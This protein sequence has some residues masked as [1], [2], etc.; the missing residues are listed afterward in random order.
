MDSKTILANYV[1]PN[2][3]LVILAVV[4]L[5]VG[6]VSI[7]MISISSE[8]A[9]KA[10]GDP[11]AFHNN[12]SAHGTYCYAD[13]IGISNWLYKYD[14]NTYYTA[15]DADGNL[16]TICVSDSTYNAMDAQF[17]WW[18]SEDEDEAPPAPYRVEGIAKTTTITIKSNLSTSWEISQSEYAELFGS[19]YLDTKSSP[20][21]DSASVWIFA[22]IM[23]FS[24][25]LIFFLCGIPG[26]ANFKKCMTNLEAKNLLDSAARELESPDTVQFGKDQARLSR[27]FLYCKR[28]GIVIPYTDILWAYRRQVKQYFIFTVS[29]TLVVHTPYGEFNAIAVGGNDK[30]NDLNQFFQAIAMGNPEVLIGFTSQNQ[31]EFKARKQAR[32][33]G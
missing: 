9:A 13:I 24:C 20:A 11:V 15:M 1:K 25:A 17:Q 5:V 16:F 23:S 2:K 22:C 30:K 33:F 10:A 27:N 6:L 8:E 12:N 31:Q 28:G 19:V 4:L 26:N 14:N 32:K 29:T 7:P 3:I 18:M 21:D